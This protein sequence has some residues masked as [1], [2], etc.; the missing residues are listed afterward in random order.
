[1]SNN[2]GTKCKRIGIEISLFLLVLFAASFYVTSAFATTNVSIFYGW[3]GS[4]FVP[5][6]TDASGKLQTDINI[7]TSVGMNPKVNN[8]Y[9]LGSI[10]KIWAN[11]YTRSVRSSSTLSLFAGSTEAITILSS[12]FVGIGTATPNSQLTINGNISFTNGPRIMDDNGK[13]KFQAGGAVNG[14][15]SSIFFLDSGG[16]VRG[17]F[18]MNYSSTSFTNTFT[19]TSQT[20][21]NTGMYNNTN[22]S[23]TGVDANLTLKLFN[24]TG[25]TITYSGG[26]TIHT[27][28]VSGTFNVTGTGNVEYLVVAGGGGGGGNSGGGGGAGGMLTGSGHSVTAQAY[29]ITVGAGGAGGVGGT[30]GNPGNN[31]VFDSYTATGGGYGSTAGQNAGNGG[32]GGGAGG[33][34]AYSGGTGT[35]GQGNNG[36]NAIVAGI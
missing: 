32:S 13:L 26:Y 24:A 33:N 5:L 17:R 4:T 31:S 22:T 11:I 8:T 28:T 9:D 25:G 10:T 19:D 18:E 27:F 14:S 23:G 36:G 2:N 29:S 6:L 3:N 1:M 15:T 21:F 12:G 20:D 35:G 30:N 7:T 16:V 34:G